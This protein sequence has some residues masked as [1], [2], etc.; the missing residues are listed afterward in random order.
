MR[1]AYLEDEASLAGTVTDWLHAAGYEVEWFSSGVRCAQAVESR[2]FDACLFDWLVPDLSGID[3][4]ARLQIKLRQAMPPVVFT[5]GRDSEED[6]VGVLA[7]GAD[8]YIVKPL[9]RP[10]LLARL[11]AVTRRRSGAGAA[12]QR[13]FGRLTVDYG[14]RLIALED[15]L[16]SLTDRETDLALYLFK[17]VGRALSREHLIQVV[18]SLTPDI[19]TRTVDV[20]VSALR[21]KL[22]LIPK[23]GWRLTSIYGYGYRLERAR[24]PG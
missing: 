24:S 1:I 15:E 18:W 3:V 5:T 6:V 21:R 9:S 23:F 4:L 16:V 13:D 11:E 17:N 22:G 8:D 7:A 12:V 20:H 14:R 10:L 19:D 2:R